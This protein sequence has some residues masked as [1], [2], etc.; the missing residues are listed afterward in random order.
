MTEILH[1]REYRQQE[2][3]KII[4]DLH[5]GKPLAEVKERFSILIKD[6]GPAE[7]AALEQTLIREGLPE[8]EIKKIGRAH[9]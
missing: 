2:L 9:V 8:A 7:I 4:R 1:S 5:D 3:K 6:I